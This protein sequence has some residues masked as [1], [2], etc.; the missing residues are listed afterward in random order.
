MPTFIQGEDGGKK[1]LRNVG[2]LQH[3]SP[4]HHDLNAY[5]ISVADP[6]RIH[7]LGQMDVD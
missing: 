1:V 7:H 2:T 5:K 4:A 3:H 6:K